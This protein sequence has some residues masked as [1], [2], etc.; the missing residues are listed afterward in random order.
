MDPA[1]RSTAPFAPLPHYGDGER[2][3]APDHRSQQHQARA[4]NAGE[5]REVHHGRRDVESRHLEA[6][7]GSLPAAQTAPMAAT[8]D[9]GG[10]AGQPLRPWARL[11]RPQ[12]RLGQGWAGCES[13]ERA[14]AA[15]GQARSWPAAASLGERGAP[16]AHCGCYAKA[17]PR[18]ACRALV[19]STCDVCAG[20]ASA[21]RLERFGVSLQEARGAPTK[22]SCR[23][24]GAVQTT[25]GIEVWNASNWLKLTASSAGAGGRRGTLPGIGWSTPPAAS[26]RT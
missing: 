13:C 20:V 17:G 19:A 18:R 5:Q 23:N 22:A 14:Q 9:G 24:A 8:A 25:Q 4:A 2:H 7:C 3:Q 12:G 10:W 16:V 21:P 26:C 6:G 11:A 1:N 15:G